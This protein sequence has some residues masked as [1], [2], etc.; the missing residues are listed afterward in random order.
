MM[1]SFGMIFVPKDSENTHLLRRGE[2]QSAV[3]TEGGPGFTEVKAGHCK[4]ACAI[5]AG[6]ILHVCV[7]AA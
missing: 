1:Y 2:E 3:F 6:A 5:A 4:G 7:P